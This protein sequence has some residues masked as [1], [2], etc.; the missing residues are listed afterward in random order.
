M[1]IK[2]DTI[3]K[4]DLLI[5]QV[6]N[7]DFPIELGDIENSSVGNKLKK[8]GLPN[9]EIPSVAKSTAGVA[10]A[11]MALVS[12]DGDNTDLT[13]DDVKQILTILY[14]EPAPTPEQERAINLLNFLVSDEYTM[15]GDGSE[16]RKKI[17]PAVIAAVRELKKE[18]LKGKIDPNKP[19]TV[20]PEPPQPTITKP[21]FQTSGADRNAASFFGDQNELIKSIFSES[22]IVARCEKMSEISET[23]IDPEK[24]QEIKDP[25]KLLQYV[26]F[27]DLMYHISKE[28]D[29]RTGGYNFESLCA[30]ICGG[31]VTGGDMGAGDF[32]AAGG[33]QGSSKFLKEYSASQAASNFTRVGELLHYIV[34]VKLDSDNQ[35]VAYAGQNIHKIDLHYI[36]VECLEVEMNDDREYQGTKFRLYNASLDTSVDVGATG[37]ANSKQVPVTKIDQEATKVG[38]FKLYDSNG[39]SYIDVLKD[40]SS[41]ESPKNKKALDAAKEFFQELF[42]AEQN[43]KSYVSGESFEKSKTSGNEAL[44][45]YDAADAALQNL[46][47]VLAPKDTEIT[48]VKGSREITENKKKSLK[49]LDKLIERV[50]LEHINK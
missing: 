13:E 35:G 18:L 50:I 7:E 1:A 8:L 46:L 30:L 40:I 25:R 27:G 22:T 36:I 12:Q 41:E 3:K 21:R 38:S 45:S 23:L 2:K 28:L 37:R 16:T 20:D 47:L 26:Q 14:N 4:L 44:K 19:T 34:A 15:S 33:A 9:E 42:K 10:T 11:V 32:V 29:G 43:T 31:S 48:G 6:L 17:K 5:E 49:D 39:N 24:I